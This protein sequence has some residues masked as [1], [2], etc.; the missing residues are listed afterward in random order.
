LKKENQLLKL[1]LDKAFNA[2]EDQ[3]QAN[4]GLKVKYERMLAELKA[5]S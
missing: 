2:L 1:K 5:E 4:E 3:I